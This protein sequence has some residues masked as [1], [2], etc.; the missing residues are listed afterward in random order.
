MPSHDSTDPCVT[1]A[2]QDNNKPATGLASTIGWLKEAVANAPP[3]AEVDGRLKL[4][5]SGIPTTEVKVCLFGLDPLKATRERSTKA[6]PTLEPAPNRQQ[7]TRK[8]GRGHRE[9]R[10][11]P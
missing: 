5:I 9:W 10:F 8:R 2:T 11:L 6:G 1:D 7:P 3:V 4:D